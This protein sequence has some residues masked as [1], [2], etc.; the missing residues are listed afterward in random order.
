VHGIPS[1]PTRRKIK[2]RSQ[3]FS[4]NARRR[5]EIEC[6]AKHVRPSDLSRWLIA[7]VWHNPTA[8]DQKWS[9]MECARRLGW[10]TMQ[11]AD[12]LELLDEADRIH[13]HMRADALGRYLG[14]SYAA[15]QELDIRTI[16]AC[17]V[18]KRTR[19]L[20]RKRKKQKV[21]AERRLA[22]GAQPRS[23]SLSATK[24]WQALNMSR[25]TWYERRRTNSYPIV[26]RNRGHESVRVESQQEGLSR[27]LRPEEERGLPSS[28][29]A[30][31]VAVYQSMPVNWR[32]M[33]LGLPLAA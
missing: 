8:K 2:K 25:T 26:L 28:Q 33:A 10:K 13:G 22:S 16:G 30:T 32:L 5:R 6:H 18:T 7:W 27:G 31:I 1:R 12:A 4:L 24:P 17:D 14:I 3:R 21:S 9:L 19:A 23:K 20:M 29:T 15:R 11:E